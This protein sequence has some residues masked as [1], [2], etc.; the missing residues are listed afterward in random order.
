MIID[1][2]LPTSFYTANLLAHVI[3]IKQMRQALENPSVISLLNKHRW[4]SN[5]RFIQVSYPYSQ[6]LLEYIRE[7]IATTTFRLNQPAPTFKLSDEYPQCT[8]YSCMIK[9]P[10]I[11]VKYKHG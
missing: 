5:A 11:V 3:G 10:N 8:I 1:T 7:M 4:S 6:P 2:R 9:M